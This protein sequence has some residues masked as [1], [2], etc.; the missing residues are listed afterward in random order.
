MKTNQYLI[1]TL[2]VLVVL[3]ASS[4]VYADTISVG[5]TVDSYG[6]WSAYY[7]GPNYAYYSGSN[8]K[9]WNYNANREI[10][11]NYYAAARDDNATAT[12]YTLFATQKENG[13]TSEILTYSSTDWPMSQEDGRHAEHGGYEYA[14]GWQQAQEG[15]KWIGT[16]DGAGGGL[17]G[18]YV[19]FYAFEYTFLAGDSVDKMKY[20]I[21]GIRSDNDLLGVYLNGVIL[22]GFKD[23]AFYDSVHTDK[24]FGDIW[25]NGYFD[26]SYLTGTF[27]LNP[28]GQNTMVFLVGNAPKSWELDWN[29]G[30][31]NIYMN[32]VG[33][34]SNLQ[35][36]T[37]R[38]DFGNETPEPATLL[39][40][41]L[42][43]SVLPFARRVLKK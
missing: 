5:T 31:T 19:G 10:S 36:S 21:G 40:F 13:E 1:A 32:P 8:D 26:T 2:A 9:A 30:A 39:L 25:D 16:T 6:Q 43:F 17:G 29:D 14:Y 37:Q 7:L 28:N 3:F 23:I 12:L 18:N 20:L 15:Y 33:F 4:G 22:D 27:N 34:Y 38:P 42:S 35:F 41:G 11:D 24:N